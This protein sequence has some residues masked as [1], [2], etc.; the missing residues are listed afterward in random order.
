MDGGEKVD[1]SIHDVPVGVD[2]GR[3]RDGEDSTASSFLSSRG[4]GKE[5]YVIHIHGLVSAL[6][7]EI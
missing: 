1:C 6:R 2:I 3:N 4:S 7:V 5:Q